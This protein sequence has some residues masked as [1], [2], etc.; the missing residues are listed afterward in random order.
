MLTR[1]SLGPHAGFI[2][3]LWNIDELHARGKRNVYA[4]GVRE[5]YAERRNARQL[6]VGGAKNVREIGAFQSS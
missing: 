5:Q 1:V 2:S 6:Q 4:M 3:A